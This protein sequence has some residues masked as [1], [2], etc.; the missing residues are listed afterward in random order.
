LIRV[1]LVDDEPAV[2]DITRL[3]IEEE[4]GIVADTVSNGREAI[5]SLNEGHYDVIVSDYEMPGMDGIK[6]LTKVREMDKDIPFILFTGRG[7]EEVAI[8]ALNLG[9]DFYLQKGG[10][11][12]SQFAELIHQIR[13]AVGRKQ[14]ERDI[15]QLNRTLLTIRN[16]NHLI[17]MENDVPTLLK[18][19][20]DTLI[21]SRGYYNVWIALLNLEG[22]ITSAAE[23]GLGDRFE[24]MLQLF[25]NGDMARC[26]SR[27]LQKGGIVARVNPS[28]F[29]TGCPLSELH[30]DRG[31]LTIRIEEQG[32]I[33]GI[34][35]VSLASEMIDNEIERTLLEEI[36][37]DI[38][39]ALHRIELQEEKRQAEELYRTL[40]ESTGTAIVL[41]DN[42]GTITEMN[43]EFVRHTGLSRSEISGK[44]KWSDFVHEE[45]LH[46]MRS[47]HQ[48]RNDND[49]EIPSNYEFRMVD[50]SGKVRN[51]MLT[52]SMI[53][54]TTERVASL[55]D[56]TETHRY[57]E[58]LKASNIKLNL[59]SN[60]TRHDVTNSIAASLGYLELM[61]SRL[62]E[63]KELRK[64][65]ERVREQTLRI[66]T[67]IQESKT[68]QDLGTT[69]PT[70]HRV[71]DLVQRAVENVDINDVMVDSEVEG[72]HIL[73]DD[74]IVK[75]F[76]NL[77]DN[78]MRHATGLSE[79]RIGFEP[80]GHGG[81]LFVEDDGMGIP[82]E[83]K[84]MVFDHGFGTNT[85]LGLFFVRQVLEITAMEIRETGTEGK[86]SR[87]EIT[88]PEENLR[89]T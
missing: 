67:Q 32:R 38:A 9:A 87:F 78:A 21:N 84:E 57:R 34:L 16:L 28:P 43:E 7:R 63:D 58:A 24:S 82:E 76:F 10:E 39:F 18:G 14:S 22:R 51:I 27:A 69:E 31:E 41:F 86:G 26:G 81:K 8:K 61:S 56:I 35:N 85:G 55:N 72:V 80:N 25:E 77:L 42:E 79:I 71:S 88:V 68:Y 37:K 17:A 29:C 4:G 45:D 47:Y 53:E 40:F 15:H 19:A 36:A 64:Y 70:W 11:P 13:A 65:F 50:K 62:P 74:L 49:G 23:A 75:V 1:L 3:F 30:R 83:R 44:K 12:R 66:R 54:G 60:I 6:L 73:A 52:L 48:R 33:Y 20:C 59:L 2:L 46:R 89:L 5:L